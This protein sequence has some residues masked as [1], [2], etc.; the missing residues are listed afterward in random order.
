MGIRCFM[1]EAINHHST[2]VWSCD[3]QHLPG[4]PC[5]R[6]ATHQDD[7]FDVA[8]RDT[9]EI[10]ASG[11]SFMFGLPLGAMYWSEIAEPYRPLHPDDWPDDLH[12]PSDKRRPSF[13]FTNGPHLIV[14]TP[15]GA[16]NID[17][18]ASNCGLPFDYEHRCWVRHGDPPL[19]TVDK[20]GKTCSAGAGSIQCGSYHGFLRNG[21]LTT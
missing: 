20:A 14:T 21:E 2:T 9:G 17:S 10:V 6:N 3:A 15:G 19:I 1:V 16:W 5:N 18:R 11:V 7:V 12:G 8:R 4:E 13:T